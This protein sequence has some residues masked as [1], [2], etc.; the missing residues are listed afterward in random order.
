MI[1]ANFMMDGNYIG[2]KYIFSDETGSLENPALFNRNKNSYKY[3]NIQRQSL[4]HNLYKIYEGVTVG[5]VKKGNRRTMEVEQN[6][7]SPF[8]PFARD[9]EGGITI[10]LILANDNGEGDL[11]LDGGFTKLF[12][13]MREDGTFRYIQNIAGFTARP[14]VHLNNNISQKY[15][16]PNKITL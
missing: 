12:Y 6:D 3:N 16:R 11:I 7:I 4:S 13:N 1:N 2:K 5:S 10:L 9:S 8:I 14:E 15:Y